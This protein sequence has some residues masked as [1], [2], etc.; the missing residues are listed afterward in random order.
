M[1][2]LPIF[3]PRARVVTIDGAEFAGTA[4]EIVAAMREESRTPSA[5]VEAYRKAYADRALLW[6][7]QPIRTTDD[8]S[9]LLDLAAVGVITIAALRRGR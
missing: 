8:E 5:N 3:P 1:K 4:T 7:K 6:M 2:S 9:F